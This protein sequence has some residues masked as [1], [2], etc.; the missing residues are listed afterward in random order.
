MLVKGTILIKNGWPVNKR[1]SAATEID[2]YPYKDIKQYR[3]KYK[4]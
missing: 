3:A 4:C 1:H 2:T